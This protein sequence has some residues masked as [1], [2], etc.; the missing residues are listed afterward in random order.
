MI[1][2]KEPIREPDTIVRP[3]SEEKLAVSA[4]LFHIGFKE[5]PVPAEAELETQLYYTLLK[6]V[7]KRQVVMILLN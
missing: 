5:R 6:D 4:K 2:R 3:Y 7:Y 1:P